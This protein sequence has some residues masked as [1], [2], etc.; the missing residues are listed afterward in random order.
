MTEVQGQL[1]HMLEKNHP[2]SGVVRTKQDK[3]K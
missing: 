2:F 1:H 3:E